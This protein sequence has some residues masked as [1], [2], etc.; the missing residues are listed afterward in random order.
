[1]INFFG[2]R[3]AVAQLIKWGYASLVST[4][5][6]PGPGFNALPLVEQPGAP[7]LI[8]RTFSFHFDETLNLFSFSGAA[9]PPKIPYD[10]KS[11]QYNGGVTTNYGSF[12]PKGY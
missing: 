11:G 3:F 10:A 6:A 12:K 2:Q 1:M 9:A 7:G 4:G 8:I 5:I